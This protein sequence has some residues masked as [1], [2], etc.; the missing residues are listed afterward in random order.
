MGR[1]SGRHASTLR[2]GAPLV[3]RLSKHGCCSSLARNLGIGEK[4]FIRT[5]GICRST[6]AE[7]RRQKMLIRGASELLLF[8]GAVGVYGGGPKVRLKGHSKYEVKRSY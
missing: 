1:L 5:F 4:G 7:V 2:T 3:L 6:W 8:T